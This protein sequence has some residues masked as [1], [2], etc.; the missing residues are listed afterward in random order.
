MRGAL[1]VVNSR[2]EPLDFSFARIDIHASFLWRA[3]ELR[4]QAVAALTRTLFT[5]ANHVP[6]LLIAL[7]D[8]VPPTVFSEDLA[9]TIALCRVAG[10]GALAYASSEALEELPDAQHV[11]WAGPP[12]VTGSGARELWDALV[13]RGGLIEPFD[14][15]ELGL[16]EA[17]AS[18]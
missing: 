17:Y 8:E 4:R 9:V 13:A 16:G 2:A 7:A 5:A 15:A 1:F 6:D 12:P 10:A 14:R 18:T 11:F 3:G